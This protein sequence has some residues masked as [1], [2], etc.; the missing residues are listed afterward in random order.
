MLMILSVSRR[1]DIPAFY[2]PWFFNR[3]RKGYVLVRNPVNFHQISRI[4]LSPQV[5]DGIVFWTRNPAPMLPRL[6][7][8]KDYMYYFQFTLTP[9]GPDIEPYMPSKKDVILPAFCALSDAIGSD[10]VI[11]RYD[12]I[13][14]NP[15]YTIS[16]HT[17][18]FER[19]AKALKGYTKKCVISFVDSY[20]NTARH[21]KSL[22]LAPLGAGEMM[23][24]AKEFQ[25][26]AQACGI[27][28][29]T[30]AEDIDLNLF[31]IFHGSCIDPALFEQLL[32]RPLTVKKDPG[33]RPFCGCAASVDIGVYNSCPHQCR[34][35]YA[36][37]NEALV[38]K[39][40]ALHHPKAPLLV[41]EIGPEDRVY[42]RKVK[43]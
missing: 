8:L 24:L 6:E 16:Y 22:A 3:I 28:L 33:Q 9:Y 39:N 13:L 40:T 37:Y 11:W 10:R 35:C 4:R 29:S 1:T 42:E 41:G 15:K 21:E 5:I 27:T 18:A 31:G 2:A 17:K 14:L 26:I 36:N 20:R 19:L 30:C 23:I 7:E 38:S 34:Y 25:G 43:M 32:G 12:P